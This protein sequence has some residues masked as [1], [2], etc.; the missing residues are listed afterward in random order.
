MAGLQCRRYSRRMTKGTSK[1][2]AKLPTDILLVC[3]WQADGN[4]GFPYDIVSRGDPL[5]TMLTITIHVSDHNL[6]HPHQLAYKRGHSTKLLLAK[7]TALDRNLAVGIVYVDFQSHL[8]QYPFA[9]V[10][11]CRN[12]WRFVELDERLLD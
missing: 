5:L 10:T 12:F 1:T 11:G 2:P 7:M 3:P 8:S 6:S 9:K 4:V